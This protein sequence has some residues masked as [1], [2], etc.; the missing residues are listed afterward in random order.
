MKLRTWMRS[1]ALMLGLVLL[2]AAWADD[3]IYRVMTL[4]Y[5]LDS[6]STIYCRVEGPQKGTGKLKTS[7]SSQNVTENTAG[8]NPF[9]GIRAGD[10]LEVDPTPLANSTQHDIA[11]II[12]RTDSANVVVN[13]AVDWS[14]GYP[15]SYWTQDCGTAITD[16][17]IDVSGFERAKITVLI[18]QMDAT[19][20]LWRVECKDAGP[21]SAPNVVYP[22]Q[23]S[24]CGP[25]GTLSSGFCS[26]TSAT[27]FAGNQAV[28]VPEI[29]KDCRVGMKIDTDDGADTTTHAE[30]ITIL[31]S[32][33]VR[34]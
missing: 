5:D 17:W 21:E 15:F 3:N 19:A 4:K 6:T 33:R 8:T 22:G 11:Y 34:R 27:D 2:P 9:N 29:E 30:Q 25:S 16:G 1:L 24:D 14:A 31:L 10:V 7:G 28:D 18:K 26:F 23:S 12:T 20:V 32:G 13:P